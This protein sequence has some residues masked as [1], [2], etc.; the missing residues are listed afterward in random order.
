MKGNRLNGR[1][2][3]FLDD[4]DLDHLL[5]IRLD[6]EYDE[7]DE[8][9]HLDYPDAEASTAAILVAA[10]PASPVYAADTKSANAKNVHGNDD[11]DEFVKTMCRVM[12]WL[13]ND[14]GGGGAPGISV[15]RRA[16]AGPS[17]TECGNGNQ[18]G[19]CVDGLPGKEK[20]S[21]PSKSRVRNNKCNKS[22][23]SKKSVTFIDPVG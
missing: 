18:S 5:G 8:E 15:K 20:H 13:E 3:H 9:Y 21:S 6:D 19:S 22:S 14:D 17:A 23:K 10:D 12:P 4:V 7:N 16:K 2:Q 1:K 11:D